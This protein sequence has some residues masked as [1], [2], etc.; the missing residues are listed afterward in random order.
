[1]TDVDPKNEATFTTTVIKSDLNETGAVKQR[2]VDELKRCGYGE[3]VTFAVKLALEEALTNAIRHGN[4]GD[5]SKTVTVRY[6]VSAQKVVL[7]VRD[8]GTGFLPETVPDCTTPDR[9]RNPS[10][11]GILLIKA[12][13]DEVCFRDRGREIQITKRRDSTG[14]PTGSNG[15]TPIRHTVFFSGRV[16]GVGFRYTAQ[17]IARRFSV[18]GQV[19]NLADGRVELIVEGI[20]T[21]IDEFLSELGQ[22]MKDNIEASRITAS[23]VTGEFYEFTIVT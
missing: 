21:Q 18:T 2:I 11:R 1:M 7:I 14:L 13:M 10:G 9:L 15:D 8:Q 3:Q 6:A 12:Y 16:Q 23:P 17:H 5:A 20:Q 22:A 4:A 19:D